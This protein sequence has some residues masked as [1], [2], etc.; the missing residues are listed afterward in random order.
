MNNLLA[1]L[2]QA[3]FGR[4]SSPQGGATAPTLTTPCPAAK[5]P[6][7]PDNSKE[8]P[9]RAVPSDAE[10]EAIGGRKRLLV[11]AAE[12]EHRR[13]VE[14]LLR[15]AGPKWSALPTTKS[16]T[17]LIDLIKSQE[18][19]G[20]IFHAATED[21]ALGQTLQLLN[22]ELPGVQRFVLCT[23]AVRE[24]LRSVPGMPPTV[25][26][27]DVSAENLNERLTH[28]FL[29]ERW[30]LRPEL[31]ALLPQ[32]R[33]LPVLSG[34]YQRILEALGDSEFDAE[35]V[36]RLVTQEAALTAQLLKVVNSAYFGRSGTITTALQAV[37]VLG[38][39]RLRAVVLANRAFR[40]VDEQVCQGISPQAEMDHALAV[41][42]AAQE[43]G[44]R[45]GETAETRELLFTA[46]M[47]HD[48]GKLLLVANLPERYQRIL[49][50]SRNRE[51]PLWTVEREELG[52]SHAEVGAFMLGLWG[53]PLP[54]VEAVGYH[55]E[56]AQAPSQGRTPLAYVHWADCQVHRRTPDRAYLE[57]CGLT[58]AAKAA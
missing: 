36:A 17:E 11:C 51:V 38:A 53:L 5:P 3:L 26:R 35:K 34:A 14:E 2:F 30:L 52:T 57:S 45:Q 7:P 44:L 6:A 58:P 25:L 31:R 47:L 21:P 43:E 46:A 54:I 24:T 10:L 48:L 32:I 9:G 4:R 12:A 40:F 13:R 23:D 18:A 22:R 28:A 50:E 42:H 1:R 27:A 55:H 20:V 56:P 29:I 19:H 33:L 49:R 37:L 39:A 41:A 16:G 15:G 8:A